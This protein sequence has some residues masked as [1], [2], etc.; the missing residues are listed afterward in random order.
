MN[1]GP[2]AKALVNGLLALTTNF[3]IVYSDKELDTQD[4]LSLVITTLV[5]AGI[6]FGVRNSLRFRTAKMVAGLLAIGVGNFL[7]GLQ[8]GKSLDALL[9]LSAVSAVISAVAV[10]NTP[11]AVTSD[12]DSTAGVE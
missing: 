1:L 5:A 12:S 4:I 6:V 7:S 10:Y 3:A 2:V 11:N 9:V 8:D